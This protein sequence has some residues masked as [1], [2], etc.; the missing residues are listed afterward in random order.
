MCVSVC[1]RKRETERDRESELTLHVVK[2]L[3][4]YLE[5]I[6]IKCMPRRQ[7]RKRKPSTG[8]RSKSEKVEPKIALAERRK[9]DRHNEARGV[10]SAENIQPFT[11][12]ACGFPVSSSRLIFNL[13]SHMST[14]DLIIKVLIVSLSSPL[15]YQ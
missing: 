1:V 2:E 9:E 3:F 14:E 13:H 6:S 10:S 8:Y 15:L 4:T 12:I 11:I 5:E 7:P